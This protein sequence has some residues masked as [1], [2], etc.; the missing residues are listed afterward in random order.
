MEAPPGGG[1]RLELPRGAEDGHEWGGVGGDERCAGVVGFGRTF[2][3]EAELD[4]P[5]S[6]LGLEFDVEGG[7][8]PG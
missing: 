1:P 6:G 3:V 8:A 2:E 5:A 4:E 7:L